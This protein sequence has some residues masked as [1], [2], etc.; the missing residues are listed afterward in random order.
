MGRQHTMYMS[1][2]TWNQL[3][4]MIRADET[5]SSTIRRCI[6]ICS[7]NVADFDMIKSKDDEIKR[8]QDFV[9]KCWCYLEEKK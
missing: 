5:M 3:V 9:G 2:A 6:Q 8:L 1:E 4:L 7:E